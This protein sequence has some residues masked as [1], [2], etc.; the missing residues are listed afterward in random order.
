MLAGWMLNENETEKSSDKS[1]DSGLTKRKK[2]F[3]I[4]Q[5]LRSRT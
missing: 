5:T 2:K 1:E 4:S 3:L